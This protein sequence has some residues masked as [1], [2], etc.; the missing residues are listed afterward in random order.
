ML[1][2]EPQGNHWACDLAKA[3]T[4]TGATV[5]KL[6]LQPSGWEERWHVFKKGYLPLSAE[7][8]IAKRIRDEVNAFRPQIMLYLDP[9]GMDA[10][11]L[12]AIE[13]DLK[14][15]VKRLAWFGDCRRTA[16]S[17][18]GLFETIFYADSAMQVLLE[19]HQKEGRPELC[20]L[21]L[22]VDIDRFKP[23]GVSTRE[24]RLM[25][26]GTLTASRLKTLDRLRL[27]GMPIVWQGP[28]KDSWWRRWNAKDLTT[29]ELR[30]LYQAYAVIL[31][32]PQKPKTM[33]GANFRIFEVAACQNLVL[34]KWVP[35]LELL[36]DPYEELTV[37]R[38]WDEAP[39]VFRSL[40]YDPYRAEEMAIKARTRVEEK[41]TFDHRVQSILEQLEKAC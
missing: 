34:T 6:I 26:A 39:L 18:V 3:F 5:Q 32:L 17:G 33:H 30:H 14:K 27:R 8:P 28:R 36:F 16:W 19:K 9:Y 24:N 25:F 11:F 37:Y 29:E 22:A 23:G 12:Q 41:H 21:P 31:N 10:P 15:N 40:M 1:I 4:R 38:D 13:R 2:T 7:E 20:Y 35:D